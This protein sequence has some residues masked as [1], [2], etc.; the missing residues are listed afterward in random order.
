MSSRSDLVHYVTMAADLRTDALSL[1]RRAKSKEVDQ[2][3]NALR[4]AAIAYDAL[5]K[6]EEGRGC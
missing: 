3:L 5:A 4:S 6:A 1:Q 2:A